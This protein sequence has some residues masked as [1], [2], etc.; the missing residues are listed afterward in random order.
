MI[1]NCQRGD[2]H[3]K[4]RSCGL[5]FIAVNARPAFVC[6][7]SL[8]V[9]SRYLIDRVE[10]ESVRLRSPDFADV[11]VWR[12]AVERLQAG[13]K[14]FGGNEVAKV[15]TELILADI[16]KALDGCVLDRPVHLVDLAIRPRMILLGQPVLDTFGLADHTETH[17]P[18]GGG[19]SIAGLIGKL[20][21]HYR[22][23]S[24]G[25]GMAPRP[26]HVQETPTRFPLD[27]VHQLSDIEL[28]AAAI[29]TNRYSFPS[30][31]CTSAMSIWKKPMGSART[32]ANSACRHPPLVGARFHDAAGVDTRQTASDAGTRAAVR[33]GNHRAAEGCDAGTPSPSPLALRSAP[34]S[35]ATLARSSDPR[36]SRA[37]DHSG[38]PLNR[39]QAGPH[40]CCS[41]NVRGRGA[42]VTNSSHRASFH[43]KERIAPSNRGIKHLDCLNYA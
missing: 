24:Y 18:G 11:F 33:K 2:K 1:G 17:L 36:P 6:Q 4:T 15:P 14:V 40:C 8:V 19:V 35:A 22:S 31:V 10:E 13:G 30:M 37:C 7:L 3:P 23:G 41:D 39:W 9:Q 25:C 26:T 20:K 28:A 16:V 38:L 42:S 21:C 34:S 12:E 27:R 29:A 32:A 5:L 43:S